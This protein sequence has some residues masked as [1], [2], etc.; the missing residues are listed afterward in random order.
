LTFDKGFEMRSIRIALTLILSGLTA[1]SALSAQSN[2]QSSRL[3]E[4]LPA[5]VAERILARI[6]AARVHDLPDNVLEQ[7]ALKFAAKGVDPASI[8]KSVS[9]H[10]DRMLQVK[11]TLDAA[12]GRRA[13]SGELDAGADALR[14]GLSRTLLG[15]LARTAPSGRSLEMPL[16]ALGSL[17]DRGLP[18]EEA[19]RRVN[20]R[21]AARATDAEFN[22]LATQSQSAQGRALGRPDNTPYARGRSGASVP[23]NGGRNVR[24]TSPGRGRGGS[25]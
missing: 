7:R 5:D 1:G 13:E 3:R 11:S 21:L 20:A 17:L 6:A 15:E 19:V 22:E 8:E 2:A 4:V 25:E 24:P 14:K 10:A 16:Y 18:A 9:D 12:R 23:G